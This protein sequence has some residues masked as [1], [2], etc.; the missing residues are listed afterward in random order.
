MN[1][2]PE[3]N[4]GHQKLKRKNQHQELQPAKKR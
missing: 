3:S 4:G 1:E 2:L